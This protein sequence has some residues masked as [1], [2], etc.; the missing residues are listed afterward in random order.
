[1]VHPCVPAILFT[2]ICPHSLSFRPVVLPDYAELELRIAGEARGSAWV[3]FDGKS[4]RE[5]QR[6]DSVAVRMSPNPVPTIARA[7]STNDWFD[8]LNRCFGWNE[9]LEQ[10]PYGGGE[11]EDE[12]RLGG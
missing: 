9:R 12:G 5:L 8:T 2:P 1:M 6:G 10:K 11:W 4:R 7:D 3:C